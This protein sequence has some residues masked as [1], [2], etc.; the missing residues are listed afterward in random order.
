MNVRDRTRH[1]NTNKC[2][3]NI[4]QCQK[5]HHSSVLEQSQTNAS[6]IK[7]FSSFVRLVVLS[8]VCFLVP[9]FVHSYARSFDYCQFF[10]LSFIISVLPSVRYYVR[11]SVC[12]Y[13]VFV[14]S[15]FHSFVFCSFV[16]LFARSAVR[17]SFRSSSIPSVQMN[18]RNLIVFD[19]FRPRFLPFQLPKLV[20]Q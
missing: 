19:S 20:Y 4:T 3:S 15:L 14:G 8:F 11:T 2:Q 7:S 9:S 16:H 5:Q 10:R 12:C 18:G 17:P 1:Q 13:C 6:N